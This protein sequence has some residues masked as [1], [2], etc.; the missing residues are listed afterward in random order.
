MQNQKKGFRT[1]PKTRV[2]DPHLR[3]FQTALAFHQ[4]GKLSEAKQ[5]YEEILKKNPN[6]FD[7]LH[8]SGVVL[9]QLRRFDDAEV[10]YSQAIRINS[11]FAPL[12]SNRGNTLKELKRFDEALAS[13]DEA[14]SIRSD[15]AEAFNNRGNA[16]KEL[17]RFNDAL[18]SYEQ[19][20]SINLNYAEAFNN[21]GIALHEL[22]RFD[23]ALESYDQAISI[24]S[25]YVEAFSNRGNTLREIKRFDE[26]LLSY[27]KAI[28]IKSNYAEAFNNRGNTLKQLERFEEALAYFGKAIAIKSNYADAFFN[29]GVTL[30]ALKRYH[31]AL[32]SYDKSI[33]INPG[34]AEAFNNRGNTL[35]ELKRYDEAL[36]S[37]VKAISIKP[38]Y[39]DSFNNCGN[40]LKELKRFD[41]ALISYDKAIQ[42][43]SDCV[44]AFVN[45]GN[46]LTELR[47]FN[48][49]LAS[50]DQAI[51]IKSDYEWLFGAWLFVRMQTSEWSNLEEVLR[52]FQLNITNMKSV[53][54]PF[55]VLALID[56]LELS[57]IVARH[58]I[59]KKCQSN[60][61]VAP[62][63]RNNVNKK[64]R[65]GYFSADFHNH[66]TAFLMAELFERHDRNKFELFAFSFGAYSAGEMRKRLE[67]S[68]DKFIDVRFQSDQEVAELSRSLGVDIGVDL[69]GFT[70]GARTS[71]FA[72]RCAP[73]QVNYI[74]YP[75]TMAADFIDY[76][77]A[78][79]ILIPTESQKFYCEKVV[80]LPNSY[81]VNDS[82]REISNKNFTRNALGLP[83]Q[84][85]VFCCFN[86]SYKI[87]PSMFD[88]WMQVLKCVEGSV[89][90]LF[91]DNDTS[92][93]NLQREASN[94]GISPE[95]LVFAKRMP[96][97]DHLARHRFADLF[98]DTHPCNAHTTASDALWA[99]LPVLT[100]IGES[101]AAR[102]AASLLNAVGLPEL[103]TR[104]VDEYEQLAIRLASH[105][106]EMEALKQKLSDERLSSK[107]FDTPLYV[108]HLE[109]AY[110]AMYDRNQAGLEPDHIYVKEEGKNVGLT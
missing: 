96:L 32:N 110:T 73:V 48:E 43:K 76:I 89:L 106:V 103:I 60:S 4:G 44:E 70:T 40:T 83:E 67:K 90:W 46:T 22:K 53:A 42:I 26:A 81:Q 9:F 91:D 10:F 1:P 35:H 7:A 92:K 86:A 37:Y 2:A 85:F 24:K 23:E 8:L 102:V 25:D 66:A 12:H 93:Q 51:T 71:I 79:K 6:H 39:V 21:R 98:L 105:P 94:R 64:I 49:A 95:R 33:F 31:E 109:A 41:E 29:C 77:I 78:D 56:D 20:I 65:I 63:E 5:L 82:K 108:R 34:F 68:F 107:L 54:F 84:G 100:R 97:A 38:N 74:G 14:I 15:F 47:R 104:S 101:F 69:K 57:L 62:I 80:Y 99:G 28:S 19:A 27:D 17:K 3:T 75:G 55:V 16:L 87:I 72:H 50:Y 30:Y 88:T 45:L 61:L 58:W 13:Y 18:G 59:E 52:D 11:N 36:R